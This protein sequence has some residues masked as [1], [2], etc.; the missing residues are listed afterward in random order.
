MGE[1]HLALKG[2]STGA[3]VAAETCTHR[4]QSRGFGHPQNW[5]RHISAGRRCV[6]IWNGMVLGLLHRM[7]KAFCTPLC[8]VFPGSVQLP[9]AAHLSEWVRSLPS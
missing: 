8:T 2:S 3:P 1:K 7:P 9:V 5:N 4:M 6:E